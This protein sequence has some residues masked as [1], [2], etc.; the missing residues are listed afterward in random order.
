MN[1]L[2][3]TKIRLFEGG[4]FVRK[5]YYILIVIY[6]TYVYIVTQFSKPDCWTKIPSS[7]IPHKIGFMAESV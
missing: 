2:F 5:P 1:S 6:I 7:T 4:K 3:G